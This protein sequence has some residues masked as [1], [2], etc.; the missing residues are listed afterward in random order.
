MDC[1]DERE[2]RSE[3]G[4]DCIGV[5]GPKIS[6]LAAVIDWDFGFGMRLKGE[7]GLDQKPWL[8]QASALQ[9]IGCFVSDLE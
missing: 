9:V 1:P 6:F 4:W 3:R 7:P 5:A 8:L 2:N